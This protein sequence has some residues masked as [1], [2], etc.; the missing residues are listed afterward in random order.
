MVLHFCGG[1][2]N[3]FLLNIFM[4]AFV[5][6][7]IKT[8]YTIGLWAQDSSIQHGEFKQFAIAVFCYAT[9]A[10][11]TQFLRCGIIFYMNFKAS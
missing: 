4:A 2:K 5:Y 1:W 7:K 3:L 11:F 8:D 9:G 6:C 10:A